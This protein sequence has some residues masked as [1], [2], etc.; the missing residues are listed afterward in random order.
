MRYITA[1]TNL[2]HTLTTT[3]YITDTQNNLLL[4][5]ST[6]EEIYMNY[7]IQQ[8]FFMARKLMYETCYNFSNIL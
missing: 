5:W 3:E 6:N 4:Y 2:V 1:K 8:S 7:N